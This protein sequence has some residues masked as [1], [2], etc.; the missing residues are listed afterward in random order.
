MSMR[1]NINH[2]NVTLAKPAKEENNTFM[3]GHKSY[4]LPPS[5]AFSQ[6][7]TSPTLHRP[8]FKSM[9]SESSGVIRS[10]YQML[11]RLAKPMLRNISPLDFFAAVRKNDI[12]TLWTYFQNPSN[13]VNVHD[14]DGWTA[15]MFAVSHGYIDAVKILLAAPDINV[16]AAAY[17]RRENA[18]IIA[19][20]NQRTQ[21]IDTILNFPGIKINIDATDITGK[22]A[23]LWA[24]Y[25]GLIDAVN[26]L[27]THGANVHHVDSLGYTALMSAAYY[28]YFSIIDVLLKAGANI[29][30]VNHFGNTALTWVA[31][32]GHIT[33]VKKLLSI[34]NIDLTI[35]NDD[36]RT[37][38]E[39]ALHNKHVEIYQLITAATKDVKNSCA[40][41]YKQAGMTTNHNDYKAIV[42]NIET[43]SQPLLRLS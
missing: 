16:N 17:E 22:T 7:P 4:H 23:L 40:R 8:D 15:L 36:D 27:L 35:K 43:D 1:K 5:I 19:A 29:N 6:I 28:N 21:I 3:V 25:R 30:A 37:A 42:E 38:A 39:E 10:S 13:D 26:I 14:K 9:H 24:A 31:A 12:T 11:K 41:F 18:L 2:S 32:N 34:P 33:A 20:I